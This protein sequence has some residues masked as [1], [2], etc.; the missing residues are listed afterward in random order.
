MKSAILCFLI[1]TLPIAAQQ[2]QQPSPARTSGE[3]DV[4]VDIPHV[5]V[6]NIALDVEDLRAHVSLDARVGSLVTISAGADAAIDRVHLEISGVEAEVYLVVR[7]DRVAAI[8]E[9]T[10]DTLDEN[11]QLITR[12]ADTVDATVGTVGDVAGTALQPGGVVSEAVGTVG[13]TLENV[14]AP[15]G[16]LSETVN[17]LGQTVTRTLDATGNIVEQTVDRSGRVIGDRRLGRLLDLPVIRESKNTAGQVVRQVR[18]T[19]GAVIEYTLDT[20]G[21]IVSSRVVTRATDQRR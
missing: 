6:E 18:D 10:L 1:A 8:I 5:Y 12:L 2:R 17:N 16:V 20:A 15:G 11:P 7:L 13:R 14:T 3:P 21:N 9:R 19:S 4:V